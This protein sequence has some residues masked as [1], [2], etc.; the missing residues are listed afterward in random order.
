M[1]SHRNECLELGV[2]RSVRVNLEREGGVLVENRNNM[3]NKTMVL[4]C[5]ILVESDP[6]TNNTK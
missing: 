4:D 6:C 2:E 1:P 5:A 3:N